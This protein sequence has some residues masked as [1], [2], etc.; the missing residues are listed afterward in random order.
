[1][2][3]KHSPEDRPYS[4]N[5]SFAGVAFGFFR[6][7]CRLRRHDVGAIRSL[8]RLSF[9]DFRRLGRQG[10]RGCGCRSIRRCHGAGVNSGR[11]ARSGA[12]ISRGSGRRIRRRIRGQAGCRGDRCRIRRR[13]GRLTALRRPPHRCALGLVRSITRRRSGDGSRLRS[14]LCWH[15]WTRRRD[16]YCRRSGG[17]RSHSGRANAGHDRAGGDRRFLGLAW[18]IDER[19]NHA[20]SGRGADRGRDQHNAGGARKARRWSQVTPFRTEIPARPHQNSAPFSRGRSLDLRPVASRP[21][22]H[23]PCCFA[24]NKSA[25]GLVPRLIFGLLNRPCRNRQAAFRGKTGKP[26]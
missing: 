19:Q 6:R 20:S 22:P 13:Y 2:G 17:N 8:G 15:S 7:R 21:E 23:R 10:L 9:D 1:M 18:T 24:Q 5:R 16:D 4:G 11:E 25:K 12:L 14:R 26:G 3:G